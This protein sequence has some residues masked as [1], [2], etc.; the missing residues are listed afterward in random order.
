MKTF[1]LIIF[2]LFVLFILILGCNIKRNSIQSVVQNY[3]VFKIDSLDNYYLIYV[4]K[5]DSI[6]KIVSKKESLKLDHK[7]IEVNKEYKLKLYSIWNNGIVVGST[8]ILM[9][10]IDCLSFEKDTYICIERDSINDLHLAENLKGLYYY[11][12]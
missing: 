3:R 5:S 1:Y 7:I 4:R 12:E 6:F 9:G 2:F 8:N 10:Q 11:D